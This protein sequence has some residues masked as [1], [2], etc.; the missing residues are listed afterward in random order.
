[1][2]RVLIISNRD[3]IARA[4]EL[5]VVA[6]DLEYVRPDYQPIPDT[7]WVSLE[8]SSITIEGNSWG[9]VR[10]WLYIPDRPEFANKKF[11]AWIC[12]EML[13]EPGG[14]VAAISTTKMLIETANISSPLPQSAPILTIL[15]PN[16]TIEAGKSVM[17]VAT[18]T[19]DGE[20]LAGCVVT[21]QASAG[22]INPAASET[23]ATGRAA[24]T[25]TA[26]DFGGHF[27]ITATYE[28]LSD[29]SI[30]SVVLP[31]TTGVPST[32]I[33]AIAIVAG[34]G[35]IGAAIVLGLSKRKR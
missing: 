24:V 28:N 4:F 6:P 22:T 5:S 17:L 20:P 32:L 25:Y 2:E 34:C 18:L 16:F 21:W 9:E 1:M 15:P 7:N 27:T 14:I 31:S 19:R 33:I 10:I 11:E 12:T 29:F 26:P 8:P 13:P 23:D 3:N 35:L 30:G